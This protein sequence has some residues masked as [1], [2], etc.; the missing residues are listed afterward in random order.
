MGSSRVKMA[1]L[2]EITVHHQDKL[3]IQV[4]YTTDFNGNDIHA[5]GNNITEVLYFP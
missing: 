1:L 4:T 5:T 2:H 3:T